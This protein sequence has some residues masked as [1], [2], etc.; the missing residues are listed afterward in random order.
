MLTIEPRRI[1][2]NNAMVAEICSIGV[3]SFPVSLTRDE[4]TQL[5]EALA[6]YAKTGDRFCDPPPKPIEWVEA[7]PGVLWYSG[8]W[9]IRMD[10]HGLFSLYRLTAHYG[11]MFKNSAE[12]KAYAE[13]QM[14]EGGR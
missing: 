3:A 7:I 12:A 8:E 2:L 4:A 13:E 6:Y 14:R 1:R 10:V 9:L 11:S 5:A